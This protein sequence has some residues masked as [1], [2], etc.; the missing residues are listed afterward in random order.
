MIRF[1]QQ[2]LAF[3]GWLLSVIS[4]RLKTAS[5]RG[6]ISRFDIILLAIAWGNIGYAAGISYLRHVGERVI[7]SKGPILECGSGATTLL[8]AM[9]TQNEQRDFVIFEHNLEWYKHLQMIL[10]RLGFEQVKL[11]HAPLIDYGDFRWYSPPALKHQPPFEL[12]ICDG[13]PG[14]IPGGR[15]G[16]LPIMGKQL[17]SNCLI[18]LDD[19]HRK[20]EQHI[21]TSW[22]RQRCLRFNRM[23]YLGTYSEVEFC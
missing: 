6:R 15:Y 17:S 10:K 22:R 1:K 13:P 3:K 4:G 5:Q 14:S 2:R 9:L 11:I 16:L 18:L 12:V 7:K 19:T 20:A 8:I 21:I 23:G